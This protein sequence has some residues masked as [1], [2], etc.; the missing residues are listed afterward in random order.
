MDTTQ[1]NENSSDELDVTKFAN[2]AFDLKTLIGT[3]L[4]RLH[5]LV[6]RGAEKRACN[7]VSMMSEK[8]CISSSIIYSN[9]NVATFFI[10]KGDH[11]RTQERNMMCLLTEAVADTEWLIEETYPDLL[12]FQK[13][14]LEETRINDLVLLA[15]T[16]K[17]DNLEYAQIN[18]YELPERLERTHKGWPPKDPKGSGIFSPLS[19]KTV[20]TKALATRK[21]ENIDE[22]P[23]EE[24]LWRHE[25]VP[26]ENAAK[27]AE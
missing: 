23:C 25:I 21:K 8:H 26:S 15:E 2:G 11:L 16:L 10:N 19:G 3:P 20:I 5:L 12:S 1:Q 17:K 13:R 18:P 27:K 7:N 4:G 9:L 22:L 6:M 24:E 14:L